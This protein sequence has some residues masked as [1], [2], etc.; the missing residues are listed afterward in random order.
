MLTAT[1]TPHDSV[2]N[3]SL[4]GWFTRAT[5]RGT[6][7]SCFASRAITRLSS[8]SPVAATTTSHDERTAASSV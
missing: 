5:T 8:S 3:H 7:N 1:S 2:N 6:A 4:S